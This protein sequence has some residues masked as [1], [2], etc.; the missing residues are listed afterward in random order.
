MMMAT[1]RK[2]LRVICSR[3]GE[4][5]QARTRGSESEEE[6]EQVFKYPGNQWMN[7][8]DRCESVMFFVRVIVSEG[9]VNMRESSFLSA[10]KQ[11]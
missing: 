9:M 11:T 6:C 5:E 3:A 7:Q 4:R 1:K 8:T 2:K 10:Q